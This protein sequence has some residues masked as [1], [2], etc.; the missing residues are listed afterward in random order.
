MG[1]SFSQQTVRQHKFAFGTQRPCWQ[2]PNMS[3]SEGRPDVRSRAA[4]AHGRF[5][6]DSDLARR[7]ASGQSGRGM[8]NANWS[9]FVDLQMMAA[10]CGR[11]LRPY[12][13]K[14]SVVPDSRYPTKDVAG[15]RHMADGRERQVSGHQRLAVRRQLPQKT[16]PD[17]GRLLG[18]VFEAVV[19]VGV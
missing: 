16:D 11:L 7:A 4:S 5:W 18:V 13:N 9:A 3:V 19:P 6:P 1:P 2:S 8:L 14:R 15:D 17:A 10:R 12:P